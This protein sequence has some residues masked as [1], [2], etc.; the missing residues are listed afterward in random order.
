MNQIKELKKLKD[1]YT[2]E[3]IYHITREKTIFNYNKLMEYKYKKTPD[4]I[5]DEVWNFENE[6]FYKTSG[7]GKIIGPDV[8]LMPDVPLVTEPFIPKKLI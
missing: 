4:Y 7:K 3:E 8:L 2:P 1:R 6:Y 5:P